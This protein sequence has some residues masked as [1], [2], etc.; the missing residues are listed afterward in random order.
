M[1]Y[2][3]WSHTTLS[4]SSS[5]S[6]SPSQICANLDS[7]I[8]S[9][10]NC[11]SELK[12]KVPRPIKTFDIV[13]KRP[14][15]GL[16]I[17]L[18]FFKNIKPTSCRIL[19][20]VQTKT[21]AVVDRNVADNYSTPI[22]TWPGKL[23]QLN[24]WAESIVFK[25]QKLKPSKQFE[26]CYNHIKHIVNTNTFFIVGSIWGSSEVDDEADPWL[27]EPTSRRQTERVWHTRIWSRCGGAR[28]AR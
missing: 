15:V 5:S 25:Q 20:N 28:A 24:I 23:G 11:V 18:S 17:F 9:T 8:V 22:L 6:F 7:A 27:H 19:K 26:I 3:V 14:E 13:E 1:S 2:S 10:K 21:D 16:F 4:S 12:K